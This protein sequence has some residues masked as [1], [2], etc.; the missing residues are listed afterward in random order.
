[1]VVGPTTGG[2]TIDTTVAIFIATTICTADGT[3]DS[4]HRHWPWNQGTDA[5]I[6]TTVLNYYTTTCTAIAI[7]CTTIGSIGTTGTNTVTADTQWLRWQ[8]SWSGESPITLSLQHKFLIHWVNYFTLQICRDSWEATS[9][10]GSTS[11]VQRKPLICWKNL[12]ISCLRETCFKID[13]FI[14]TFLS[15]WSKYEMFSADIQTL[16]ISLL[17]PSPFDQK[18]QSLSHQKTYCLGKG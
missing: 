2:A 16:I 9:S 18:C 11:V 15:D 12:S 8:R 4:Q 6:G 14:K 10:C 1:M 13:P 5:T 3:I 17:V 7:I